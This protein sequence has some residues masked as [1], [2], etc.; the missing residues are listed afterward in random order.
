M[1]LVL[2]GATG[3]AKVIAEFVGQLGYTIAAVFD[4]DSNLISPFAGI[5]IYHDTE[6][7]LEWISCQ[8]KSEISGLAALGGWRGKDRICIHRLMA[9]NGVK[10]VSIVHPMAF[11]AESAVYGEGTQILAQAAV[12]AEARLGEACI[13][14]TSASVD[15]ECEIGSGVHLA[16]GARLGGCVSVGDYSFLGIGAVVLPRIHIGKRVIVGA[17]S[18]VTHDLPDNVIAFGVPARVVRANTLG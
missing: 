5:P 18:V 10:I 11:V 17:G 15:H 6:T 2:W 13:I 12:C 3:Q 4:Q 9:K 8:R 1:P 16:P 7:F 14:N